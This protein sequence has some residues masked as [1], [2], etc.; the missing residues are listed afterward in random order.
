MT[1]I[2]LRLRRAKKEAVSFGQAPCMA[3]QK[4]R[5][6]RR[7]GGKVEARRQGPGKGHV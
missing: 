3:L 1:G 6:P 4:A 7:W 5:G 2:T